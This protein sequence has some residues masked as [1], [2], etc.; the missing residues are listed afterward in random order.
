MPLM[1]I[2][3]LFPPRSTHTS[4]TMLTCRNGLRVYYHVGALQMWSNT[5]YRMIYSTCA[6]CWNFLAAGTLQLTVNGMWTVTEKHLWTQ[7]IY[8]VSNK[9]RSHF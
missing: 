2:V 4:C 1:V 8:T 9:T 7:T 6:R 3:E 5:D